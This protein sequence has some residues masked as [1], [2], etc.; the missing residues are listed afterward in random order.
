MKKKIK[1]TKEY[2]PKCF[3]TKQYCKTNGIC[4]TCFKYRDC[5]IAS[6]LKSIKGGK[7]KWE[8]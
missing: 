4:R 8:Q 2:T 7:N 5:G 6:K 1:M 3:K